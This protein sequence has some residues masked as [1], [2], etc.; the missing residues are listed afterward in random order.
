MWQ[1]FKMCNCNKLDSTTEVIPSRE[2][3][4]HPLEHVEQSI[5]LWADLFKCPTCSQLWFIENRGGHDRNPELAYKISEQEN[6]RTFDV[7]PG[8]KEWLIKKHGGTS[9]TNCMWSGCKE[10]A[11]K[12]MSVCVSHGHSEFKW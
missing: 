2:D 8:R 11:L 4:V 10:K 12:G 1:K 6:W 3:F 9:E 7:R 5:E